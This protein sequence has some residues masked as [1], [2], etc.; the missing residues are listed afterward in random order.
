M[1]VV[2]FWLALSILVG[3]LANSEGRSGLC[4][5]VLAMLISPLLAGI[6][7]LLLGAPRKPD[8]LQ[9]GR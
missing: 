6:L 2:L 3:V 4:W 8:G 1:E 9:S 7:V 5:T